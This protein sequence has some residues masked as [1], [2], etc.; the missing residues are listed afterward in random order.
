MKTCNV[1][2]MRY[3]HNMKKLFVL[4]AFV[5][6]LLGAMAFGQESGPEIELQSSLQSAQLRQGEPMTVTASVVKVRL[7]LNSREITRHLKMSAYIK[8]PDGSGFLKALFD[9]GMDGDVRAGDGVYSCRFNAA[10]AG[11]YLVRVIAE[12]KGFNRNQEHLFKALPGGQVAETQA[13]GIPGQIEDIKAKAE[14]KHDVKVDAETTAKAE[15][16]NQTPQKF[17]WIIFGIINAVVA[18]LWIAGFMFL[19]LRVRRQGPVR[20]KR[21]VMEFGKFMQVQAEEKLKQFASDEKREQEGATADSK[22]INE[23]QSARLLFLKGLIEVPKK[24]GEDMPALWNLIYKSFDEALKTVSKGKKTA[25]DEINVLQ[26]KVEEIGSIS[27]ETPA[28]VLKENEGLKTLVNELE[29]AIKTKEKE[30]TDAFQRFDALES[31]YMVLYQEKQDAQK[32]PDI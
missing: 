5:M 10:Q 31:E 28:E 25:L 24:A 4:A 6:L 8:Q 15:T 19:Y 7:V 3:L 18:A 9:N 11:D 13:E 1:N 27:S 32:Q 16:A 17:S 26:E 20:I 22:M 30:L 14:V 21:K 12:G 29:T 23:L 2:E